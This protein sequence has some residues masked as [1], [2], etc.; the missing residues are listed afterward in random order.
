MMFYIALLV[1]FAFTTKQKREVRGIIAFCLILLNIGLNANIK[2]HSYCKECMT[3]G[4]L[5][6]V[7]SNETALIKKA[8]FSDNDFFRYSGKDLTPNASINQNL[9]SVRYN[10]TLSNPYIME[11]RKKI[12]SIKKLFLYTYV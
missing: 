11:F 4:G 5:V 8:A 1:F 2:Y 12:R 9:S 6:S 3:Q 7:L 10:W